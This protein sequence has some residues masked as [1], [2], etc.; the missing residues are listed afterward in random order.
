M[1]LNMHI[2]IDYS[3]WGIEYKPKKRVTTLCG[4][5]S[6]PKYCGVPGLTSQEP[7]VNPKAGDYGWCLGCCQQYLLEVNIIKSQ[8]AKADNPNLTNL[9]LDGVRAVTAQILAVKQAM[10]PN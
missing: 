8:V 2:R 9:Y 1:I 5:M 6:L 4:K 10:S 7:V 3:N